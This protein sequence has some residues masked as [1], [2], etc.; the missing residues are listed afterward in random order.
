MH[1][2][3]LVKEW[4][5]IVV[6]VSI[7][8]G[9]WGTEA[10]S[11]SAPPASVAKAPICDP[12]SHP[13]ITKVTPDTVK[14]GDKITIKGTRFGTKECFQGVAFGSSS[15]NFKYVNDTT[16][17]ATVP[18][19]KAGLAPVSIQTEAGTSQFILLIQGK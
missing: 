11:S 1:V 8:C 9:A 6:A 17:E 7:V 18:Q 10:E 4:S 13:K 3:R 5:F 16:I 15:A 19:L 2:K 14:P 12:S